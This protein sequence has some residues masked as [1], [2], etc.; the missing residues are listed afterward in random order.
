MG[1]ERGGREEK[2][3]EKLEETVVN[4][5]LV[6]REKNERIVELVTDVEEM[7]I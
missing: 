1:E 3:M 6:L 2:K 4:L 7:K 5:N